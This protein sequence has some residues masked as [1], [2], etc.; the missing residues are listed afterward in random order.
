[1]L[2]TLPD[3]R[4]FELED[5]ARVSNIRDHGDD[6]SSIVY[7][8]ISFHISF[9]G[10]EFIEV[11]LQYHFADWAEQKMKL[12]GIR[13]DLLEAIRANGGEVDDS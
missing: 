5:I 1:M 12:K 2:Y 3:Q 4:S 10:N 11:A 7:S 8:K 13:N 9:Q 6:P